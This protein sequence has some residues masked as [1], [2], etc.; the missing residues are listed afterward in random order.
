MSSA[1]LRKTLRLTK[2]LF[3]AGLKVFLAGFFGH[4]LVQA[5]GAPEQGEGSRRGGQLRRRRNEK[6]AHKAACGVLLTAALRFL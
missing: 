4:V 5:A 2:W 6:E 1:C 3:D